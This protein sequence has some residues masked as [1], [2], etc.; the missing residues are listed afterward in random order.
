MMISRYPWRRASS[1]YAP[2]PRHKSATA[3]TAVNTAETSADK[4]LN[5][6]TCITPRAV[7]KLIRTPTLQANRLNSPS[8]SHSPHI[9]ESV[10]TVRTNTFASGHAMK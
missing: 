6:G 1:E 4:T 9:D 7:P 8:K 2:G 10:A 5:T 3:I